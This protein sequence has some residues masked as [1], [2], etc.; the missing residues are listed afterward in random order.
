MELCQR[1]F[2]KCIVRRGSARVADSARRARLVD[3]HFAALRR[4]S[5]PRDE[6]GPHG[7]ATGSGR[8]GTG[9]A[10]L[11]N[12][13]AG[14]LA[15]ATCAKPTSLPLRGPPFSRPCGAPRLRPAA[16][17]RGAARANHGR[18]EAAVRAPAP[19]PLAR[20]RRETVGGGC[21]RG[22]L[23]VCRGRVTPAD[24]VMA[25]SHGGGDSAERAVCNNNTCQL[26]FMQ[27]LGQVLPTFGLNLCELSLYWDSC[28]SLKITLCTGCSVD[29]SLA[30]G[31]SFLICGSISKWN[32]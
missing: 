25:P 11:G 20:W 26:Q 3:R 1:A 17:R 27:V 8:P 6:C 2:Q 14:R 15:P 30:R 9:G 23:H 28:N 21:A 10:A 5:R 24:I 16:R 13:S 19:Q 7:H 29:M 4:P 32:F 18:E 22:R 12:K 31:F